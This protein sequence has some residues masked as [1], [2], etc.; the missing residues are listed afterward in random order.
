M[1]ATS[2]GTGI[3]TFTAFDQPAGEYVVRV[4]G[5]KG[6]FTVTVEHR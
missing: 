6:G 2:T 3:I 1:I 4:G 5:G